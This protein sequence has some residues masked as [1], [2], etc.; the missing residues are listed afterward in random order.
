MSEVEPRT[1]TSGEICKKLGIAKNTLFRW[2]REGKIP[3]A[4]RDW[5]NHRYY[6]ESHVRAIEGQ[7]ERE[8]RYLMERFA[9]CMIEEKDPKE[10][11]VCWQLPAVFKFVKQGQKLGLTELQHHTELAPETIQAL[12]Q[13]AL[14]Q[15]P[16]SDAFRSIIK[17]VYSKTCAE[18]E[19][20]EV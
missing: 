8:L 16:S 12:L 20:T 18:P 6:T 3:K 14:R 15:D 10:R 17:L 13:E 2:E 1:Y 5:R 19:R 7:K 4:E 9:Q 11:L